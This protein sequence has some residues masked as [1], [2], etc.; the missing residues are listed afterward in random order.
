MGMGYLHRVQ[1][2]GQRPFDDGRRCSKIAGELG[3]FVQRN[4]SDAVLQPFDQGFNV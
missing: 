3:L 4:D 2:A 1:A